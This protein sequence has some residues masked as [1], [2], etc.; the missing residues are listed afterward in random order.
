MK[1]G[2]CGAHRVGKT[3]LAEY[4]ACK[5]DMPFVKTSSSE[6]FRKEG[7]P[8]DKELVLS[9]RISIQEKLLEHLMLSYN[10]E[11]FVTDR[12]PIDLL[13]Y[14][15]SDINNAV[16]EQHSLKIEDYKRRCLDI[17]NQFD[18]LVLIQPGIPIIHAD[19]KGAISTSYIDQLNRLMYSFLQDVNCHIYIMPKEVL[20]L[21]ERVDVIAQ[22]LKYCK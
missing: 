14:L 7:L 11:D 8:T 19:G 18:L 20:G 6:V 12:T 2:I 5:L 1:I 17:S 3:T 22:V 10:T 9:T 21:E 16:S 4:L 13:A 15:Y